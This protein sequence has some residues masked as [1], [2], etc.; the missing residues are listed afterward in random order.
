MGL[1]LIEIPAAAVIDEDTFG[2]LLSSVQFFLS[3]F[4]RVRLRRKA[5]GRGRIGPRRN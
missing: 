2:K 1:N 4:L 3:T 5:V